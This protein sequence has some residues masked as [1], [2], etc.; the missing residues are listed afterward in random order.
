MLNDFK[1]SSIL[2]KWKNVGKFYDE[3]SEIRRELPCQVH[4][5]TWELAQKDNSSEM[6]ENHWQQAAKELEII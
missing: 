4:T 6:T 5:K 3:T 2:E 1:K